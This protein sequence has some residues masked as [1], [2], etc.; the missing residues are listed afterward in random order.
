M[1]NLAGS[2]SDPEA[3]GQRNK[4]ANTR[5]QQHISRLTHVRKYASSFRTPPPPRAKTFIQRARRQRNRRH[6]SQKPH[7]EATALRSLRIEHSRFRLIFTG[8]IGLQHVLGKLSAAGIPI[9]ATNDM[10]AVTVPP[11]AQADACRLAEDLLLGENILCDDCRMAADTIASQ[12]D[13]SL[14]IAPASANRSAFSKTLACSLQ[15]G[16]AHV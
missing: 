4:M 11:L 1:V 16:R 8:S 12:V 6:Q 7:L 14:S 2:G 3:R 9:S 13:S 5:R 10:Y 15:I